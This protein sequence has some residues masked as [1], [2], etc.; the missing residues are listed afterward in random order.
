MAN[1]YVITEE[2]DITREEGA[3]GSITITVASDVIDLD[4]YSTVKFQ[5]RMEDDIDRTRTPVISKT[6]DSGI[7][8]SGQTVT[9]ALSA[10]DTLDL[11]GSDYRW[12]IQFEGNS[13]VI[14]LM[15]GSFIINKKIIE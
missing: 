8:R 10:S 2:Q 3:T 14:P 12:E 13:E 15:R 1:S 7:T 9:I 11:Y 5:V 4:T 6:S